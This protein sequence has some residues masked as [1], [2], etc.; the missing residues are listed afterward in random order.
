MQGPAEVRKRLVPPLPFRNIGRPRG[1]KN[2]SQGQSPKGRAGANGAISAA[3]GGR[4]GTARLA[5]YFACRC[6]LLWRLRPNTDL[7]ADRLPGLDHV[8][9]A[10]FEVVRTTIDLDISRVDA[11]AASW[12]VGVADAKETD[13]HFGGRN[14]GEESHSLICEAASDCLARR[15]SSSRRMLGGMPSAC[16]RKL[17]ASCAK[18]YSNVDDCC[19][20]QRRFS[21]VLLP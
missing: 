6:Y 13:I 4:A 20:A 12:R 9:R 18:R 15:K 16:L 19:L 7:D 5:K 11:L 8:I 1:L 21:M 17:I 3:W 10:G 14:P 2:A